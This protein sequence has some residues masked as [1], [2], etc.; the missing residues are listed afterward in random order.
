MHKIPYVKTMACGLWV[1][2]GSKYEDDTT[3]GL[4]HLVEHLKLNKENINNPKFKMLK[5]NM[6]H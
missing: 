2:Q 6:Y 3:N 4:S 1:N 5:K